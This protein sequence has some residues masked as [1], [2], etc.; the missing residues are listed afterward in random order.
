[1]TSDFRGIRKETTAA[2]NPRF[3]GERSESGHCDRFWSCALALHA[4]KTSTSKYYGV[5]I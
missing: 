2:G 3:T 4:G 5:L 1:M